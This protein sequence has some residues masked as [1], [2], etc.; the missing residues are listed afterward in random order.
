MDKIRVMLADD[1]RSLLKLLSDYLS[2]QPDIELVGAVYDGMEI[3]EK[4]IEWAPDMLVMDIIMPRQDGFMALE[5]LGRPDFP[6]KPR[7]IVLTGLA[8]DDFI[9]RA[10]RLGASYYMV[11]PFDMHLLYARIVEIAGNRQEAS[12]PVSSQEGG[13][14]VDEQITNLF[15]ALG[16]PAHIKG[17]QYLREAVRMVLENHDVINRITKELYPAVARR[18]DTSASKVERAM[19]HAIGVAW[20][21]GRIDAV[22]QMYGTKVFR[23]ED[24]PTNGEFIALVSDKIALR[25]TA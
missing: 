17:Y 1:N 15:L 21:R 16:I 18:F 11:K 19:R 6:V 23:R 3:P 7:V 20:T 4:V 9:V 13:E 12:Q 22:N 10:I 14:S 2:R 8:R 5:K 24:K 25:K